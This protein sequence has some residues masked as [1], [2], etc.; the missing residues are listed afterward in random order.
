[1]RRVSGTHVLLFNLQVYPCV[2]FDITS[3]PGDHAVWELREDSDHIGRHLPDLHCYD[4]GCT[5]SRTDVGSGFLPSIGPKL[6]ATIIDPDEPGWVTFNPRTTPNQVYLP[7]LLEATDVLGPY[8]V[9]DRPVYE[10]PADSATPRF[11]LSDPDRYYALA[12]SPSTTTQMNERYDE[13]L[14]GQVLP[15]LGTTAGLIVAPY[16]DNGHAIGA[17]INPD[18]LIFDR[19]QEMQVNVFRP[20]PP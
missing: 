12:W 11:H 17:V 7:Y 9:V 16:P 14:S 13:G 3:R 15:G 2:E 18:V 4:G 19:V 20:P 1:M 8:T 5:V 10:V 6:V